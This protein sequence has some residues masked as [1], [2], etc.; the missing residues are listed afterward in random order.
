MP[1][2]KPMTSA[3]HG[4]T[5]AH[6]AVIATRPASA[7]LPICETSSVLKITIE[8]MVAPMT[9]AA[10]ARFVLTATSAKFALMALRNEPGLKPI[11]PTQRIST[12]RIMSG[13]EWPGIGTALPSRNFPMRG[14]STSVPA[15]A[16]QSALEVDDRRSGEVLEA[17]LQ[18]PA[19]AP[20]PV[21]HD[22]VDHAGEDDGEDDVADEL[23]AVEHGAEDDRQRDRAEDHLEEEGDLELRVAVRQR[24]V[25]VRRVVVVH[26]P[27]AVAHEVVAGAEARWRNRSP[28]TSGG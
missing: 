10:A 23:R 12:P 25:V 7:P 17:V 5:K 27:A 9:P 11:Q 8:P 13:M 28:R 4:S 16:P 22:R 15:S 21:G 14:P 19:A 24:R 3:A 20:R 2:T 18:Q 6:G 1:A 26:E